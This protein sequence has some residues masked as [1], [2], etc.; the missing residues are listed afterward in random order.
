MKEK[1]FIPK[2]LKIG[3]NE[4]SDTYTK[5]LAY[6]IYYDNKGV[7]RKETSF[8]S[9]ISKNIPVIEPDNIPTEGFVLNK[10]V[11]GVNSGWSWNSRNEYVRVYDPRGFEFEISVNNLLFILCNCDCTKGKG[12]EGKF[13]YAWYGKELV[14]LPINCSEY[15]KSIEFT[16]LQG[17]KIK[18]KDLVVGKTYLDKNNNKLLYVGKFPYYIN[19]ARSSYW[20]VTEKQFI[21]FNGT[22]Y[23]PL[24]TVNSISKEIDTIEIQNSEL[25]QYNFLNSINASPVVDIKVVYDE[26]YVV[27]NGITRKFYTETIYNNQKYIY[28]WINYRAETQLEYKKYYE[29][30]INNGSLYYNY[31]YMQETIIPTEKEL[32]N[33]MIIVLAN[34][35]EF[36]YEE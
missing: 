17:L 5:K 30:K 27:K 35:K 4:R 34:G 2:K 32:K 9:W 28:S 24:K 1:L 31:I 8:N 23:I 21:F 33:R 18:A 15:E 19:Q 16:G 10:Q 20:E 25:V 14:L 11:G 7:L 3:F 12:L 36:F 13:V 6:V 29:Y 22:S 26:N